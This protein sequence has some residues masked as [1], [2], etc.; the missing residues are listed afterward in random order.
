MRLVFSI[1]VTL[2]C[3]TVIVEARPVTPPPAT[4]AEHNAG[5]EWEVV[6]GA[7]GGVIGS[8]MEEPS[9]LKKQF[10]YQG[11]IVRIPYSG[12]GGVGGGGGVTASALYK[13]VIGLELQL[14]KE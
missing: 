4:D 12:F 10:V 8:F 6:V 14:F 13:G 3:T 11:A 5:P 1:L 9:D 2:F 7:F